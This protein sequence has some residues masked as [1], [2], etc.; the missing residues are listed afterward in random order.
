LSISQFIILRTSQGAGRC[1][2]NHASTSSLNFMQAHLTT[3]SKHSRHI[4]SLKIC[5]LQS[6]V[7]TSTLK[8]LFLSSCKSKAFC[9]DVVWS[10]C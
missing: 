8:L 3:M 7:G 4:T 5:W 10:V 1:E 2:D 6:V 9:H